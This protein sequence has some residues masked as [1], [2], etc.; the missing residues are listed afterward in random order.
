MKIRLQST[1]VKGEVT[2]GHLLI[3]GCRVCDTLENTRSLLPEGEY[4]V[5]LQKCRQYHRNM[6]V[7]APLQAPNS[8]TGTC[9]SCP[10][11]QEVYANT[12]LSVCCPMLKPGNGIYR[13]TDGS[14]LVGKSVCF[15]C[16]IRNREVFENLYQRI[17]MN[18][19]RGNEVTVE[20][21]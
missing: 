5:Q 3:D 15:G 10:Q 11:Q 18:I 7:L 17:R 20:I 13:R 16:L 6:M 14:I 8:E 4:R 19:Q 12:R 2:K 21:F 1:L 9:A